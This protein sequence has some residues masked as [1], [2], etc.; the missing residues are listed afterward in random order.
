[1]RGVEGVLGEIG[2]SGG[3]PTRAEVAEALAVDEDFPSQGISPRRAFTSVD[4]PA[5]FG[6][7]IPWIRPGAIARESTERMRR[8]P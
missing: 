4:L 5:P 1:M 3:L 6:P 7:M 8:A 2:D